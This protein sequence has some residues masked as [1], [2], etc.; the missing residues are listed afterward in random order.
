MY[1]FCVPVYSCILIATPCL[2]HTQTINKALVLSALTQLVKLFIIN[3]YAWDGGATISKSSPGLDAAETQ[4]T[5]SLTSPANI[6]SGQALQL[7]NK[8]TPGGGISNSFL[9]IT[10][11]EM[12]TRMGYEVAS[13][14]ISYEGTKEIS[15]F[16][17]R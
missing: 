12:M 6:W 15:T 17:V 13:S 1:L 8:A 14:A 2:R 9:L 11:K 3:G 7:R 16:T 5:I 4:F 10:A